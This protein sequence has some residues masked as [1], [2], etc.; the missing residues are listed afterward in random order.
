MFPSFIKRE[1]R[2]FQVVVVQ[3][4]QRNAQKSAMHVQSCCSANLNLLL[5]VVLVAVA[6][7][8]DIAGMG[9]IRASLLV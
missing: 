7:V 2:K 1:N 5:F 3:R 4:R 9:D 6:V 8:V